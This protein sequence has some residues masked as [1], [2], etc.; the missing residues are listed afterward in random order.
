MRYRLYAPPEN[1]VSN[2]VVLDIEETVHLS[3]VLR[4]LQGER[5]NVF[6][7]RG[8]EFSCVFRELK[9]KQAV[10]DVIKKCEPAAPESN[11]NLELAVG[12][13][14]GE[15]FELVIQKAVEL[16][17]KSLTPLITVRSKVQPNQSKQD[18]WRKIVIQASKQCGRACLMEINSLVRFTEFI[19]EGNGKHMILFS[20]EG[21][22]SLLTVKPSSEITAIVGSEGGWDERELK[23]AQSKGVQIITLKGRILRAETAAIA[24]SAILQNRFGDLH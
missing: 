19:R 5:V 22:S 11:L 8:N 9:N 18:R 20:E 13:L 7:G 10:L 6:D 3:K 17:V 1:F 12:L 15:K 24:V 14:K 21:G 23:L 2:K 16:G 4:I